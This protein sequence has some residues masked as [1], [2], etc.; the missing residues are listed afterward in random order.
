MEGPA[1]A[2]VVGA[3]QRGFAYSCYSVTEPSKLKIVGVAEP[4]KHPREKLR[5]ACSIPDTQVFD[6]WE[7]VSLI[8]D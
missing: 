8:S 5:K 7:K 4:R 1:T 6:T 2:I 3:G